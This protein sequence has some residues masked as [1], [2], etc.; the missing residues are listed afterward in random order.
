MFSHFLDKIVVITKFDIHQ[1]SNPKQSLLTNIN[2][3]GGLYTPENQPLY[4]GLQSSFLLM[5]D[6]DYNSNEQ[7]E[8]TGGPVNQALYIITFIPGAESVDIKVL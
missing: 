1:H 6:N 4:T 8:I 7:E 2:N 5:S 3:N